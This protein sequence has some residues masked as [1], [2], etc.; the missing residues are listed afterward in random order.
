[1]NGQ[2]IG[3]IRISSVGQNTDRQLIDVDLDTTFTDIASGKDTNRPELKRCLNH[4][5]FGDTLHIHSIDR[6][7]RSLKDLQM[8]V[9][10]INAKGVTVKFYKENL[11]FE[12]NPSPMQILMF[13]MLG[14]F[15]EFERSL[16][17]N[18]CKEGLDACRA[19]GQ[20]LGRRPKLSLKQ[21]AE[22]KNLI[23]NNVDK[24]VIAIE[25]GISRPT[26][27]KAIASS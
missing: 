7:A 2:N 13:Q 16:I 26:L 24:S 8:I 27:Y 12:S 5:R 11:M 23:G 19:R 3:Y 18:R 10:E 14:A 15:A 21:I 17:K 4:A 22:I 20:K 6:L 25:Y 9:E 1:M